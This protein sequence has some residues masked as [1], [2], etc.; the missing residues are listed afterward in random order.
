MNIQNYAYKS[1]DEK[2]EFD[3][4]DFSWKMAVSA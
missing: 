2:P 1:F 3:T 4:S